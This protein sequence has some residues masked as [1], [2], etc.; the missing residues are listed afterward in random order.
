MNTKKQQKRKS[1]FFSTVLVKQSIDTGAKS[2]I[3]MI[4]VLTSEGMNEDQQ[5]RFYYNLAEFG[6]C[7][8]RGYKYTV[9]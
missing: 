1:V 2:D 3:K 9:K 5:S 7:V 8:F 4:D 6:N